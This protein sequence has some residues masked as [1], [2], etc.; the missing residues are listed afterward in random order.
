MADELTITCNAQLKIAT[1]P[2]TVNIT[3]PTGSHTFTPS[4]VRGSS[5]T[6]QVGTSEESVDFGDVT[7]GYILLQNLDTQN[8]VEYSTVTTDYDLRLDPNGGKAL[9]KLSGSQTLYLKANTAEC[10]V[11]IFASNA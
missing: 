9:I 6:V 8:Y 1:S 7:P 11:L 5:F 3:S 10:S 2:T 4:T